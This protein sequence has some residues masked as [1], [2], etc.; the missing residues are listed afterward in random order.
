LSLRL[1]DV[2]Q[3][4]TL[5]ASRDAR[6]NLERLLAPKP[7][8]D[9]PAVLVVEDDVA[10]ASAT[11][12]FLTAE[13]YHVARAASLAEARE[14]AAKLN[15]EAVV[16]DIFLPDGSG[17]DYLAELTAFEGEIVVIIVSGSPEIETTLEAL[18]L[19]ATDFLPKPIDFAAL[20][21]SLRRGM[22]RRQNRMNQLHNQLRLEELILE[23]SR[24]LVEANEQL[25]RR[26]R[27]L[28]TSHRDV[29]LRLGRASQWRDDETGEHIQRIGLFSARIAQQ[30]GL[31][32]QEVQLIREA[33]PM[34]DIGKIGVP[35]RILLKPGA[36]TPDEY[37]LMKAHT[38]IGAE[39]LSGS[40][41]P[42]LRASEQIALSHHER[43]DGRG[44]P[45]G[46]GGVEIPLFA[47]IVSAADIY[48]A[49]IHKRPYK[50]AHSHSEA[51]AAVAA[52]HGTALDPDVVD[53]FLAVADL[54]PALEEELSRSAMNS[55]KY[56]IGSGLK[57]AY[58]RL[59]RQSA[60]EH[61]LPEI[62]RHSPPAP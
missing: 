59:R 44:Y 11:T 29:I 45:Y 1:E 43:W 7:P 38:L 19:G 32:R 41:A 30:M 46:I 9:Q 36:L 20:A 25:E 39:I 55:P 18:R 3:G 52:M 34:H 24:R 49:M 35:D 28:A 27:E 22:H 40:S 12:Q 54:L 8:R 53:A 58:E 31:S 15:P 56:G 2:L 62:P 5:I 60:E 16:L 14:V 47:R 33:S 57:D 4:P 21:A 17:I 10:V 61:A 13:G 48:D 50:A 23:R 42:I 26:A 6:A 51:V 37:E